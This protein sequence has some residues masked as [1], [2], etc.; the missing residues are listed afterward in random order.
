MF[1]ERLTTW[2]S[3][4]RLFITLIIAFFSIFSIYSAFQIRADFTVQELFFDDQNERNFLKDFRQRF[5]PDDDTIIVVVKGNQ[6]DNTAALEEISSLTNRLK[7]LSSIRD[8][9]SLTTISDLGDPNLGTIDTRP[10]YHSIPDDSATLEKLKTRALNS[11]LI[12]KKILAPSGQ[13]S[14]IIAKL[15]KG[16]IRA[17]EMEIGVIDVEKLI[18]SFQKRSILN[19]QLIGVPIVRT[20]LVRMIRNDQLFFLPL[21]TLISSFLLIFLYRRLSG[22]LIP[23]TTV[24][25]A[26][27]YT[28]ALLNLFN[29]PLDIL[30]NIL[31]ILIMVYGIADAVHML[32]RYHEE[33]DK[34]KDNQQP[35]SEK[36]EFATRIM[37]RHLGVACL[38]TS[39]T[40]A[41][42]F[43]SLSSSKLS[44]MQRFGIFA[45]SGIMIAYLVSLFIVPIGI[46]LLIKKE[47][48][49]KKTPQH[50]I[51][52][53][54]LLN[55]VSNFVI[56]YPKRI[57]I[58]AIG[59]ALVFVYLGSHVKVDNFLLGS[60]KKDHPIAIATR[61]VNE[62]LRG[63]VNMQIAIDGKENSIKDPRVLSAMLKLQ[64]WLEK[65]KGVTE[66][67]SLANYIE[68]LHFSIVGKRILP[69]DPKAVAQLIFM[70]G[71]FSE[72]KRYVDFKYRRAR[73]VVTLKDIG[74]RRYLPLVD[75]VEAHAA[76]VF[77]NLKDIR[78]KVTGTSMLAY[79]GIDTL[80]WNLL[81]SLLIAFI[82]IA[83]LLMIVFRS[84]TIGLITLIPNLIPLSFGLGFM[85]LTDIYL[86]VTTVMIYSIAFGIAVDDTIH[87][88]AR[89]KEELAKE[90]EVE[91]AIKKTMQSAAKAMVITSFLLMI[92]F[93]VILSS[94]FPGTQRFGLL[95]FVIISAAI[96]ADLLITPAVMLLFYSRIKPQISRT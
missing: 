89:F 10:I 8:V 37:M 63:V 81:T 42:G 22:L 74:A 78:I 90:N 58:I 48:K 27:S 7:H 20:E 30:N 70:A 23:L 85:V 14:L 95:G 62:E 21:S 46:D 2:L 5:G 25:L 32:T 56:A 83:P 59:M 92:G 57:L 9:I 16:L 44:I 24:G 80:V 79:Q 64:H 91:I 47:E 6:L 75:R 52:I 88:V 50:W 3:K 96:I 45:S 28:L 18:A 4:Y 71:D 94:N 73:I 19:Y 1:F 13:M 15:K 60:L 34:S 31:P 68:E 53:D 54:R 51:W 69:A 40:T 84:V 26:V 55:S 49:R 66:T 17:K 67:T 61:E 82:V 65:Q 38:L 11:P 43:L 29:Y 76:N 12:S 33:I 36:K 35:F 41:V 72:F 77:K 93:M 87:F 39:T 86:D